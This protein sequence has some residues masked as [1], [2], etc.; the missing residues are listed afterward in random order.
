MWRGPSSAV[1]REKI[2]R[3]GFGGAHGDA[4][5]GAEHQ[6]PWAFEFSE[7]IS[8]SAFDQIDRAALGSMEIGVAAERTRC[9]RRAHRA[10]IAA[11]P[12]RSHRAEMGCRRALSRVSLDAR[13]RA[14]RMLTR[15]ISSRRRQRDLSGRRR[16]RDRLGEIRRPT[17]CW[18]SAPATA[19]PCRATKTLT[20]D[21]SRRHRAGRPR[22]ICGI[23][24]P[25]ARSGSN[26]QGR[27]EGGA[28]RSRY[29]RSMNF[30]PPAGV[31]VGKVQLTSARLT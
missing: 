1:R 19:S 13:Q 4:V 11:R 18:C 5:A 24:S 27:L 6:Q 26:R 23:S 3:E 31:N 30:I 16:D 12:V 28:F 25:P 17:A 7:A 2:M 9:R 15:P 14:L 21:L 29:R 22:Q 8:I 10:Y 20:H